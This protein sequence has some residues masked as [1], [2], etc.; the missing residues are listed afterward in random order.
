ML[1]VGAAADARFSGSSLTPGLAGT[2]L[3]TCCWDSVLLVPNPAS[4]N[5]W[6]NDA[7]AVATVTV[8]PTVVT[9]VTWPKNPSGVAVL[10]PATTTSPAARFCTWVGGLVNTSDPPVCTWVSAASDA[11][12]STTVWAGTVPPAVAGDDTTAGP[13]P[14]V[15]RAAT[16]NVYEVP[17]VRPV[18]VTELALADAVTVWVV[19]VTVITYPLTADPPLVA[20]GC[21]DTWTPE[22][23]D[24]AVTPAGG[25]GTVTCG[26]TDAET[27]ALPR[28]ALFTA[29]TETVYAV[30]SASPVK[31]A[32]L[33]SPV[34]DTVEVA[35]L[36]VSR[37][38]VMGAP[39]SD[40]GAA[41]DTDTCLNPATATTEPG[42]PGTVGACGITAADGLLAGPVPSWFTAA[43]V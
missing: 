22:L 32:D 11:A 38:L 23:T 28:P 7:G 42:E 43:T 30:P 10:T 24:A 17:L 3:A 39:P 9:E 15:L 31:V 40:L 20:G 5:A 6:S 29:A 36:V 37:Y 26:F 21:H 4:D 1:P 13:R 18:T 14:L 8:D 34:T 25:P 2:N 33:A 12:D 16:P 27:A 19:P 35:G 41:H